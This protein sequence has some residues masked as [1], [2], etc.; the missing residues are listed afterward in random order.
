MAERKEHL[1]IAFENLLKM[2]SECSCEIF[3]ECGLSDITVKQ[4]GYLKTIDE[5]GKITFSGLARI[6]RNGDS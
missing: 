2:K 3:S 1:Y 5:H 6:T 4:V